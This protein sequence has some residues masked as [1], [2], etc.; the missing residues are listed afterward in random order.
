MLLQD[1]KKNV[2]PQIY[3]LK[4]PIFVGITLIDMDKL[5]QFFLRRPVHDVSEIAAILYD[6]SGVGPTDK[7]LTLYNDC[8]RKIRE[9]IYKYLPLDAFKDDQG[10]FVDIL[11]AWMSPDIVD[12]IESEY[13]KF[14]DAIDLNS[15]IQL[16]E[17]VFLERVEFYAWNHGLVNLPESIN[18][19]LTNISLCAEQYRNMQDVMDT[20]TISKSFKNAEKRTF[21]ERLANSNKDDILM[22]R[23]DMIEYLEQTCANKMYAFFERFFSI[24]SCS[25]VIMDVQS[26]ISS[27]LSY[28]YDTIGVYAIVSNVEI[29]EEIRVYEPVFTTLDNATSEEIIKIACVKLTEILKTNS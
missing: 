12:V 1:M 27:V 6:I 22:Y 20:E 3:T 7:A 2:Y 11:P 26:R 19:A 18:C 13:Q 5:Y 8:K 25:S 29:P 16:S 17:Q 21:A 15:Y 4:I 9:I 14:I 10:D 24:L 23:M 28:L